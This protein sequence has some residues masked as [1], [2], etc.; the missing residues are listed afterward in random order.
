[1]DS[2]RSSASPGYRGGVIDLRLHQARERLLLVDQALQALRPGEDVL[3]VYHEPP[4]R[5]QRYIEAQYPDRFDVTPVIEGPAVWTL[6]V[7]PRST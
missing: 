4:T 5:L 2:S 1:M 6:G 3:L 7:H